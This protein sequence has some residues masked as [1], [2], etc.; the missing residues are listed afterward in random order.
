MPAAHVFKPNE[1]IGDR[2]VLYR[3]G[4]DKYRR[5]LWRTRCKCG[6]ERLVATTDLRRG[7]QVRCRR[8]AAL[9]RY[10]DGPRYSSAAHYRAHR[11]EMIAAAKLRYYERKAHG[12]CV[13]CGEKP[14]RPGKTRCAECAAF[15]TTYDA[16][17]RA[18]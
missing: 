9:R 17:R 12:M 3:E 18:A 16:A 1:Q 13:E 14:A 15:R 7:R 4:S 11:E 10:G 5:A 8:C 2:T 6:V